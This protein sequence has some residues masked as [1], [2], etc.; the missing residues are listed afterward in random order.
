MSSSQVLLDY[1]ILGMSVDETDARPLA[2]VKRE[3][4]EQKT[5]PTMNGMNL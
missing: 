5:T 4:P 3:L 1:Y 2:L